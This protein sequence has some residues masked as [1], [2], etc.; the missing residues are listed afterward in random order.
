M[1]MRSFFSSGTP[2]PRI[3]KR[4]PFERVSLASNDVIVSPAAEAYGG[5]RAVHV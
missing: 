1:L 2:P 4:V 3:R 5:P